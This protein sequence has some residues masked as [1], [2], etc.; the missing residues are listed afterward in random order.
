MLRAHCNFIIAHHV[1]FLLNL[2]QYTQIRNSPVYRKIIGLEVIHAC[3]EGVFSRED[4]S[5][6]EM[7]FCYLPP[8]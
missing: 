7:Q 3:F 8:L 5:Q 4:R 2:I 6:I 1:L